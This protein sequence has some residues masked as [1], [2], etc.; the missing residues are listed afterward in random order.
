MLYVHLAWRNIWRNKRRTVISIAS[1]L[2]AVLFALLTRSM[3]LGSYSYMIR[4][5]VRIST[6]YM[7]IHAN[8]FWQKRSIDLAFRDEADL[9][10]RLAGVSH[11]TQLIPR[12][13][14]FALAASATGT[15][16]VMVNGIDPAAENAMNAL[17]A[18][19]IKGSYLETADSAVLLGEGLAL[20]LGLQPGDTL[21]LYGQ[22]YHGITAAAMLPVGGIV[23]Y[24]NPEMSSSFVFL[25]LASA[26]E[27]FGMPG[28]VNS[29]S[30]M[31]DHPR[32][33]QEAF[34]EI[35]AGLGP[36]FEL[37][38]WQEMIPEV[39]QGIEV[40]NAGGIIMI[41]IL[42]VI[43]GFGIFGTVMMMT[44]E[45]RREFGVLIAVGMKRA[46]LALMTAIESLML[47]LLGVLTG[48]LIAAP[49][50]VVLYYNPIRLSGEAA[51]VML[52]FGFEP[53]LP[54]SLDPA[55]FISQT[56]AVLAIALISTSYPM[57][58]VRRL[59][60]VSAMR[61]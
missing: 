23:R 17:G 61:A 40:D 15:R 4:N 34:D 31:L 37:M 54:F 25:S 44:L 53:L 12:L 10:E 19:V 3:Q 45:R 33:Q 1:V 56:L 46:R 6:G 39:V 24:P 50:L 47:S 27:L 60:P 28:M 13:Q 49:V 2:F 43:I 18:K 14:T 58:V 48:T 8:G 16:G 57:L 41:A 5:V 7:Q 51:E 30:V 36:E 38:T 21:I 42:Y 55:I 9:R 35:R 20:T 22:G 59:D 26:Q 52:E 32:Y 11:V 29:L